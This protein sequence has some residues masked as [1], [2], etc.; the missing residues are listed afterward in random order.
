MKMFDSGPW[1][2]LA[3]VAKHGLAQI[4]HKTL[5]WRLRS[6]VINRKKVKA[7]SFPVDRNGP[8]AGLGGRR[9]RGALGAAVKEG[10]ER[11]ETRPD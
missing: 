2:V 5:Q 9:S 4:L 3:L 1:L 11:G 10:K 7:R 6:R 8:G